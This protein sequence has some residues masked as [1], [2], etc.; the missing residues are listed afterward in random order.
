MYQNSRRITLSLNPPIPASASARTVPQQRQGIAAIDFVLPPQSS[1]PTFTVRETPP[2]S[3]S[4]S[5]G[6]HLPPNAETFTCQATCFYPL[7]DPA[8]TG[9]SLVP[10]DEDD[11]LCHLNSFYVT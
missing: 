9:P 6:L 5:V 4:M 3:G 11:T 8:G 2:G 1:A 7:D 10:A